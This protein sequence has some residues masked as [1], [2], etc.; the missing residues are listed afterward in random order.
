MGY[1][2][3]GF[4]GT[5]LSYGGDCVLAAKSSSRVSCQGREERA[6]W[7]N[8]CKQLVR[9]ESIFT[10]FV[11]EK[12]VEH[13]APFSGAFFEEEEESAVGFVVDFYAVECEAGGDCYF[14]FGDLV[15]GVR[16][17]SGL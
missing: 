2:R 17:L 6:K 8:L 3:W 14:H 5:I 13:D 1:I 4:T 9:R 15:K 7:Q 11:E 12:G 16:G 10:Y